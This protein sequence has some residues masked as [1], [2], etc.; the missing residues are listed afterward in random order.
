MARQNLGVQRASYS[1]KGTGADAYETE[2]FTYPGEVSKRERAKKATIYVSPR[3]TGGRAAAPVPISFVSKVT[4]TVDAE[5]KQ[6]WHRGHMAGLEIGGENESYNIAPMLPGFNRGSVWRG[7]EHATREAGRSAGK[8]NYV[9]VIELAYGLADPRIPSAVSVT[10]KAR[11][12]ALAPYVLIPGDPTTHTHEGAVTAR[13][14]KPE[15]KLLTRKIAGAAHLLGRMEVE[16]TKEARDALRDGHLPKSKK[17][18]WPDDAADRPYGNLDLLNL[19]YKLGQVFT[20]ESH[21]EFSQEQRQLIIKANL[22]KNGSLTSDDPRDPHQDLSENGTVDFPEVD[23]IIP[24]SS[25]G[26]NAF[27]NARVVSWEL[28]NRVARVKGIQDLVDV[29]RL[30]ESPAYSVADV[31]QQ[32]LIRGPKAGTTAAQ[33]IRLCQE[34]LHWSS[35]TERRRE[36]VAEELAELVADG[37]VTKDDSVDPPLFKAAR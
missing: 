7:V 2:E 31:V 23:H 28:N 33:M 26:A 37:E 21:R 14:E 12:S 16:N 32:Q 13:P 9:T 35:V 30:A 3:P 22:S 6:G 18:Q 20:I 1:G 36:V 29:T 27:S 5:I 34:K 15:R 24:K 8:D 17:A 19:S 11:A 4:G 25:G 10:R